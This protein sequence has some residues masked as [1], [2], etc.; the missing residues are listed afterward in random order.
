M[1]ITHK[2]F[3]GFGLVLGLMAWM[4][5]LNLQSSSRWSDSVATFAEQTR[6]ASLTQ[7]LDREVLDLQR[8]AL[9]YTNSGHQASLKRALSIQSQL[10][11]TL[12]ALRPEAVLQEQQSLL[13]GLESLLTTYSEAFQR[14]TEDRQRREDLFRSCA[15]KARAIHVA[16]DESGAHHALASFVGA[17]NAMLH[18]VE[19]P[20]TSLVR[21]VRRNC[22][23]TES[24]LLTG[25]MAPLRGEV[26]SFEAAFM[27]M[28]QATRGYLFLFNV[29]LAGQASE[30][31]YKTERLRDIFDADS[32]AQ[33]AALQADS[34]AS[35]RLSTMMAIAILLLCGG[36]MFWVRRSIAQP[37]TGITG[38]FRSLA[39]G[40]VVANIPGQGRSDEIG[41]LAEAAQVFKERNQQ[42]EEL[43]SLAQESSEQLAVQAKNLERV[44]EELEQFAYVASH[45][46]QEPLRMVAS[47]VQLLQEEYG[48]QLDEDADEYIGFASEGARRMQ[49]LINDLLELS[50]VGRSE[51]E[52]EEVDVNALFDSVVQDLGPLIAD[53]GLQVERDDLPR[54]RVLPLQFRRVL[55]NFISNA[56]KYRDPKQERSYLR[57]H[58][59]A[60]VDGLLFAFEDNGIGIAEEHSERIFKIFQRLHNR[61]EHEGNGMGL[62]IVKKI[63]EQHAGRVW[64][65]SEPGAGSTF[66]FLVGAQA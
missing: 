29:V 35:T 12:R 55:Q 18:Y 17:S 4:V 40:E 27:R 49:L 21:D 11:D 33:I 57:V 43:L 56:A 22:R 16:L 32:A 41:H 28:A 23:E 39:D 38:I 52:L 9:V 53:A 60:G 34:H 58:A 15:D 54:A 50:R 8:S 3:L 61:S 10:G 20:D 66:K 59:E 65:E 30:F 47:Y 48:G 25:A 64:V 45:D 6:L 24:K 44:N 7:R 37:I 2:I 5:A 46:L 42:T 19:S 31:S 14:L 36:T 63:A 26:T 13:D 62:A 51:A 1:S